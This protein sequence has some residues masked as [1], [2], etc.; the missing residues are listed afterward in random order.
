MSKK[1]ISKRKYPEGY[2]FSIALCKTVLSYVEVKNVEAIRKRPELLFK[3][4][5][6]LEPIECLMKLDKDNLIPGQD[7]HDRKLQHIITMSDIPR[8]KTKKYWVSS[9]EPMRIISKTKQRN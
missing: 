8:S 2:D 6:E 3:Y 5:K 1:I 9:V 7:V 4:Q